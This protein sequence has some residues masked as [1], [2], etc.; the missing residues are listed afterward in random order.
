MHDG[1]FANQEIDDAEA[2]RVDATPTLFLT[3]GSEMRKIS[4]AL[5]EAQ[6][7]E[8]IDA[9]LGTNVGNETIGH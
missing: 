2:F 3:N 1:L 8:A 5:P 9:L 4:G 6:F 7:R